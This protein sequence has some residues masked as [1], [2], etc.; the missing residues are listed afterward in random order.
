MLVSDGA[1]AALKVRIT[2]THDAQ[3][4]TS[5][6]AAIIDSLEERY[7]GCKTHRKRLL[8]IKEA[9]DTADR[10]RHA[11]NRSMVNG[12]KEWREAIAQ[13]SRSCRVL[14][15]VYG[16]SHMTI[17]RIKKQGVTGLAK[18]KPVT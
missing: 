1:V 13:D 5:D 15:G 17:S 7:E 18:R 8:I 12:T 6:L 2:G 10:L 14:A 16:V 9:Q 3:A 11:P 4:P